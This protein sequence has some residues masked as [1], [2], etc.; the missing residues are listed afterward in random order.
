LECRRATCAAGFAACGG[1]LSAAEWRVRAEK[2]APF[3]RA[4]NAIGLQLGV[5]HW[6]SGAVLAADHPWGF[7][8]PWSR[9]HCG[10]DRG[11]STPSR[12]D[13]C[14]QLLGAPRARRFARVTLPLICRCAAG[15]VMGF[16]QK[17][18]GEF[19]ATIT[20]CAISRPGPRPCPKRLGLP[21][22]IPGLVRVQ[23]VGDGLSCHHVIAVSGAWLC[24]PEGA[25][26]AL[27]NGLRR[28]MTL[29][30]SLSPPL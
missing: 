22:L 11:R 13:A 28:R 1:R 6:L 12:R 8:L 17:P 4:L 7:P 5:L 2:N 25:G 20:F 19:G 23:A 3:G 16:A 27:Q 26:R 10:C 24:P 9:A 18:M 14:R 29:S 30:L 21:L 15:T